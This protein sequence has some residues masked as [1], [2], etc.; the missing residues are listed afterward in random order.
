MKRIY[1]DNAAATPVDGVVMKV[2]SATTRKFPG[3]P[4]ALHKEGVLA[5]VALEAARAQVAEVL[6]AHADEI[7]FTSGATE[8]NN[9]AIQGVVSAARA[10]GVVHPHIIVSAIEH[11][12]VLE[13]SRVLEK[14]GVRVDYLSVNSHGVADLKELRKLITPETVLVSVM[15]ANN[16]VG[17][18]EP[19]RD[20]AKEIR[21]ARKVNESLYPYFH[22][23]AAQ[24]ANY[25]DLNVLSLGV[26]LMT[27]SSGK[28]Y[29]PRGISALFVRRG[30]NVSPLMYGGEHEQ[31]RRAGTEAVA[32]A[33][34]FAE[35]LHVAQKMKVKEFTRVQKIRD[36]FAKAILKKI[37]GST[38]NGDPEHALPNILNISIPDVDSEALV[39][40]LDA[41]GVAVSGKS[42]CTS[43]SGES[44]HVLT[45]LYGA[46]KGEKASVR[47][48]LGRDTKKQDLDYVI[49][50]LPG[51]L[52]KI[53]VM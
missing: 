7:V 10:K 44:S 36:A 2:V 12:S 14:E 48:S 28:T 6:S 34:G 22:T 13:V 33:S 15:Y 18:I 39:I 27:L 50:V 37:P 25:L 9:M 40:Y 31:G 52:E 49:K 32:L 11:P 45:A 20:I 5:R 3:N 29:G 38:I 1:L 41:A 16:E 46:Q 26:D 8:A 4:S 42:A 53:S 30:V 17:T 24:A 47:F 51:I 35:A 23:D 43:A 19:I 21:H